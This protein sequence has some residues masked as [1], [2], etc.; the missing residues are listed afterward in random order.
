MVSGLSKS[1]RNLIC[2]KAGISSGELDH[3]LKKVGGLISVDPTNV[4]LLPHIIKNLVRK[5]RSRE[6][7][8]DG[9]PHNVKSRLR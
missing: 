3:Y 1:Y 7:P 6:A 8:R 5:S 9:Y 2:R 4:H